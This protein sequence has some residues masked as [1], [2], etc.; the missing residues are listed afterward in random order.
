[1][2]VLARASTVERLAD[3]LA[4]PEEAE[5][6]SPLTDLQRHGVRRPFFL[7]HGIG[8]EVLSFTSL[9]HWLAPDQP[10]YGIRARGSDGVEEPLADVET[11]AACYLEAVRAAAP[12]G[13]YLLG[14]YSSGGTVVLEMAQQLRAQGEE[15]A[16]L[17]MIDSE[18]PDSGQPARWWNPRAAAGFIRNVVSWMVDDDFF[19]STAA[20]KMA[21]LQSK[22]RLLRARVRALISSSEVGVDIRDA[23]GVWRFPDQH[24]RFLETHSRAL[25][26]YKPREYDGPIT[27]I[28]ARTLP[29]TS[30]QPHDLG[31]KKLAKGGLEVR[32]IAG[33]H[34]N[35]LTEPRV[36]VLAAHLR[37]C[38]NSAQT[39]IA[40]FA[41]LCGIA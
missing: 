10:V 17:A 33:A 39:H 13:P 37:T 4:R 34:D 9:A 15:V 36:R 38:L 6:W 26:N 16:L 19:R 41:C 28:R 23:L 40:T 1:V 3:I 24:R 31:W 35:I 8:G 12:D 32:V 20:E 14:G 27:L 5:P 7:V 11:M 22:G 2:S 21:R 30:L 18:A 25:A 29:L